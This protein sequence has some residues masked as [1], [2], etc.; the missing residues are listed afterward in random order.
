[1]KKAAL[2]ILIILLLLLGFYAYMWGFAS[3]EVSETT[4]WP[5]TI[6]YKQHEWDYAEVATVMME[7][8]E[9]LKDNQ[10]EEIAWI[11][12]YYDDP[13]LVQTDSL[14]SN[15]GVLIDSASEEKARSIDGMNVAELPNQ[16]VAIADFP[17]K[18]QLSIFMWIGKAYPAIDKYLEENGYTIQVARTEIYDMKNKRIRY[19]APL[20]KAD[21]TE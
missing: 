20:K 21:E 1:M 2:I 7:V 19:I 6:V 16:E 10:I 12:I 4:E 8:Q 18:S 13:A 15:I 3:V 11:G 5:Y 9:V 14:R 17:Y